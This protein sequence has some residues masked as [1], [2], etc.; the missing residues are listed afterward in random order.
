MEDFVYLKFNQPVSD[1]SVPEDGPIAKAISKF[2]EFIFSKQILRT[3]LIYERIKYWKIE[4]DLNINCTTREIAFDINNNII[5]AA[6]I[7]KDWGLWTD[8]DLKVNDYKNFHPVI[9]S[10]EEFEKDWNGFVRLN[11]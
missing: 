10:K 5:K 9:I 3:Q 11:Y 4:H 7:G 6:P 1:K 8:E 2:I